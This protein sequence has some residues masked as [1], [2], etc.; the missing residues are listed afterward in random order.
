MTRVPRIYNKERTISLISGVGIIRYPHAKK[1]LETYL[2][3]YTKINS[4]QTKDLNTILES[5]KLLQENR[6]IGLINY[7][8]KYNTKSTGNE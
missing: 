8:F 7:F 1:K 6:Y 5:I 3:P 2:M 4:K